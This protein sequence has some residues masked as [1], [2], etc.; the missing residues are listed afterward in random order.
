MPTN[1]SGR[2]IN[3]PWSVKGQPDHSLSV[4][5]LEST[6]HASAVEPFAGRKRSRIGE[7]AQQ[8]HTPFLSR[9]NGNPNQRD[10]KDP[11]NG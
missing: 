10:T 6:S 5:E 1:V 11:G 2:A 4:P 7:G 9:H 8:R 3:A